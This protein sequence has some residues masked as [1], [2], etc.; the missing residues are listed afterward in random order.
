MGGINFF[1]LICIG[2]PT[3]PW[4]VLLIYFG[5]FLAS[6]VLF[7]LNILIKKLPATKEEKDRWHDQVTDTGT[8]F[9]C[10]TGS[11]IL[12][13]MFRFAIMQPSRPN[14][15]GSEVGRDQADTTHLFVVGGVCVV[16]CAG[17][18]FMKHHVHMNDHISDILSSTLALLA[19]WCLL[20]ASNW[21]MFNNGGATVLNR[22][23]VAGIFSVVAF[24]F[25]LLGAVLM[26][27]CS[28]DKDILKGMFS[29][30]ALTVGMGWEKTFDACMDGLGD[31]LESET[32][33]T[34][35]KLAIFLIVFP[36]WVIY[37]LPKT[38][39]TLNSLPAQHCYACF[40]CVELIEEDDEE[41]LH[42]IDE[43]LD[44][45]H[46]HHGPHGGVHPGVHSSSARDV[47]MHDH[48]NHH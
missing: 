22:A 40:P 36:A 20:F 41:A 46:G 38:D 34:W 1:G 26:D 43:E 8:D 35:I 11:F 44:A 42:E 18:A 19:A 2:V 32:G 16:L 39:S 25:I 9:L 23:F 33:S 47:A 48:H 6:M 10:M 13:Y 30:V 14:I 7:S 29:A 3:E 21:A 28:A 12:S 27:H 17:L 5:Y 37:I 15:D 24:A 31:F 4:Q 45:L